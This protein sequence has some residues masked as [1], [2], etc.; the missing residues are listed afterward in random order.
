M[1]FLLLS[2]RRSSARQKSRW[3]RVQLTDPNQGPS[4]QNFWDCKLTNGVTDAHAHLHSITVPFILTSVNKFSAVTFL[5]LIRRESFLFSSKPVLSCVPAPWNPE[6]HFLPWS[7]PPVV[8]S[9][10]DQRWNQSPIQQKL[11][12]PQVQEALG[13]CR[14]FRVMS[15]MFTSWI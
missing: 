9:H 11:W 7:S 12:P 15:H 6:N 3:I 1:V 13:A 2:H 5:L 10:P 4:D 8:M 14:R